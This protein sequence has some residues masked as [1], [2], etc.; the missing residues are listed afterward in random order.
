MFYAIGDQ[1]L[2]LLVTDTSQSSVAQKPDDS[3]LVST[4]R[5]RRVRATDRFVSYW[6]GRYLYTIISPGQ[7]TLPPDAMDLIDL[8][9]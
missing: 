3:E 9:G 7:P 6:N 4:V 8:L 5:G 1:S 2:E